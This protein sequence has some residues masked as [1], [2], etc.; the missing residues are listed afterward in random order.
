MPEFAC[1]AGEPGDYVDDV[2]SDDENYIPPPRKQCEC[3]AWG[4][5]T[6]ICRGDMR[7]CAYAQTRIACRALHELPFR[8]ITMCFDKDF[9]PTTRVLTRAELPLL[10]Y[11]KTSL[12]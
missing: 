7:T 4:A 11:S 1:Q 10:E 12:N 8:T 5:G 9:K 2:S 3:K 6:Q